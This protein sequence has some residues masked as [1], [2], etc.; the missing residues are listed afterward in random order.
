IV[1]AI[2]LNNTD[3]INFVSIDFNERLSINIHGIKKSEGWKNYVLS[4]VNEFQVPFSTSG[5]GLGMRGFDCVFGGNMADGAGISSSAAVEG[6]LA[7][8]IN[9]LFKFGLNRKE[10]A[11]LCQRAEHNFPG[12]MCGIM[13]QYANMFGKKDHVI[14][15]DCKSIEHQYFPLKLD[16]YEI[17]LINTKVHHSLASSEYNVRRKQCEEGLA[18]LKKEK[19]I[20][21]FRD[22]K[23]ADEL[24]PYKDKM[25]EKVYDRC[26]F[27][28]EEILR[29]QQAA[30]LLQQNKLIEFGELMFATHEGLSKL[31]E[32][33]C[34]ELDFLVGQAKQNKNVIGSRMMGGGF[35]G[36]TINI[37]K[38]ENVKDFLSNVT[39]AYKKEFHI[40]AEIIEVEIEDGTHE[41]G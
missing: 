22:I 26:K 11:L 27:V 33:S 4:V 6:G 16:G 28:V 5:E 32:V 40:D 17:V 39:A 38:N 21:S 13:D 25:G 24:L 35:G 7:F 30:K 10:L 34:K 3:E 19:G 31:Y 23:N 15:L 12:V 20:N 41:I 2:A 18:I 1:Y 9:E 36:C 14:L 29:T 8:G 37:V